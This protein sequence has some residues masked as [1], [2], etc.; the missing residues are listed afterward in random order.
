ML[1]FGCLFG[2]VLGFLLN[3]YINFIYTYI[4]TFCFFTNQKIMNG[5]FLHVLNSVFCPPLWT[6]SG[7]CS[8]TSFCNPSP[9]TTHFNKNGDFKS[10]MVCRDF[11]WRD[12]RRHEKNLNGKTESAGKGQMLQGVCS[13]FWDN[14]REKH[15]LK[16]MRCLHQQKLWRLSSLEM[17]TH[18]IVNVGACSN[19][20]PLQ[21]AYLIFLSMHFIT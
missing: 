20:P 12:K 16:R 14:M 7:E 18:V 19:Q 5:P 15:T 21:D 10:T 17:H 9:P 6:L 3:F 13:G 4:I 11:Y 8:L 2:W 1:L